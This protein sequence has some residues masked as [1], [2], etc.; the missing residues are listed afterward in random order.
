MKGPIGSLKS[1]APPKTRLGGL[2]LKNPL[3][4]PK[5]AMHIAADTM[6]KV[7]HDLPKAVGKAVGMPRSLLA[8]DTQI[9]VVNPGHSGHHHNRRRVR[10]GLLWCWN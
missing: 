4:G 10:C 8:A 1:K 5:K 9:I 2:K 6:S 7:A 3:A